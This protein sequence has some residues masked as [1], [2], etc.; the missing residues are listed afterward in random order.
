MQKSRVCT[1]VRCPALVALNCL[2]VTVLAVACMSQAS[3]QSPAD[4]KV[5]GYPGYLVIATARDSTAGFAWQDGPGPGRRTLTWSAGTLNLPVDHQVDPFS[6]QD[7]GV[8][9]GKE[10]AGVGDGGPLLL[11]DGEYPLSE[12]LLLS[13]GVVF[14]H[15]A[16]GRIEV[17]GERIR[18]EPPRPDSA[19]ADP[20]AGYI[21]LLGMVILIAVLMRRARKKMNLRS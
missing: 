15:L 9:C 10:L 1:P 3:A 4:R 20:R 16:A 19:S 2:L 14:L 18:Y 11:R 5:L 7:L 21:F 12:P 6:E 8:P 17:R 13:D